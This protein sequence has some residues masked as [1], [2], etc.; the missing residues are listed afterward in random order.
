LLGA[1]YRQGNGE[2]G[3]GGGSYA[4]NIGSGPVS[5][6]CQYATMSQKNWTFSDRRIK[7]NIIDLI[8]NEFLEI[9]RKIQPKKYEYIDQVS[10]KNSSVYVFYSTRSE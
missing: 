5:F 3:S 7:K 2:E 1:Y 9:L 6:R 4:W 8:D 10:N